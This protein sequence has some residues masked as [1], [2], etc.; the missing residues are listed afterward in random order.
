MSEATQ[1]LKAV[2]INNDPGYPKHLRRRFDFDHGLWT[3]LKPLAE[4]AW[5]GAR[6]DGDG[7]SVSIHSSLPRARRRRRFI[8]C[9]TIVCSQP[10]TP[11]QTLPPFEQGAAR[12]GIHQ[13]RV[14]VVCIRPPFRAMPKRLS[15]DPK[16]R[17]HWARPPRFTHSFT[18]ACLP[19]SH[20]RRRAC[21]EV[22]K[23][24]WALGVHFLK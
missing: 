3:L 18:H 24:S 4:R 8:L 16:R 12:A 2:V 13:R 15:V 10:T 14:V 17:Q 22:G 19:A 9:H 20:C 6:P 11:S 23:A 21:L 5:V 7:I 1:G